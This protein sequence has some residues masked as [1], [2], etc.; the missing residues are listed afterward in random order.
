MGGIVIFFSC[1][2]V[3][4]CITT[5]IQLGTYVLFKYVYVLRT[6][7]PGVRTPKMG[8]HGVRSAALIKGIRESIQ[9]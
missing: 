4:Y 3:W 1:G 2:T 9:Q 5:Y 6:L 8:L 7:V